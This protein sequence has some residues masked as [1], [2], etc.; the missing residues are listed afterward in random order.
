MST[1][2]SGQPRRLRHTLPIPHATHQGRARPFR[3][4][5]A[6][7]VRKSCPDQQ[8]GPA[9]RAGKGHRPSTST[10]ASMLWQRLRDGL[11]ATASKRRK[12]PPCVAAVCMSQR[13][14]IAI[15]VLWDSCP[16]VICIWSCSALLR[17]VWA[18]PCCNIFRRV[19]RCRAGF[20]RSCG[21]MHAQRSA[22]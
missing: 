2:I 14:M 10:F 22:G 4:L 21:N 11:A 17:K 20:W 12:L 13:T 1:T 7:T 15:V 19:L 18:K 9:A 16:K 3:K 5:S 8:R 6:V